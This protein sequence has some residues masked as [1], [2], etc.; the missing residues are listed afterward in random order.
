[1][2]SNGNEH[3]ALSEQLN[4]SVASELIYEARDEVSM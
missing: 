1:M 2:N 3:R 4:Y